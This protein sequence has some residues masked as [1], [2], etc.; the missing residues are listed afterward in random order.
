MNPA[1]MAG[2][3][4]IVALKFGLPLLF[5]RFPFAAGWANFVLDSV[6]GDLLVP[7]GLADA[8]YQPIDKAA[9]W[10]SYVLMVVAARSWPIRR[11]TVALFALRSVGQ[12]AFFATGD[13]RV[14][15]LFPNFLEPLFLAYAT[16]RFARRADAPA[17]YARHRVAVWAIVVL[18]KMQDEWVTHIGNVDRTE[19]IR[20]LL[21]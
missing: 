12:A 13:E 15:F 18:Y 11:A 5:V 1:A 19:L 21:R 7:L 9:D 17:F 2:I 14:F 10:V 20:G 3:A 16:I 8:T 4:G 6:D